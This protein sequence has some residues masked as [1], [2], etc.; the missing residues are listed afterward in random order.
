MHSFVHLSRP[1]DDDDDG[2]GGGDGGGGD[3]DDNGDPLGKQTTVY[4]AE[5]YAILC[6]VLLSNSV[7]RSIT[8]CSDSQKMDAC[9]I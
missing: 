9:I 3:D 4:Q 2:G 5:V 6:A 1:I 8:I 7:D